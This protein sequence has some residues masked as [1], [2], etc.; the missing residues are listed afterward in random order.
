MAD[1]VRI[2]RK[3]VEVYPPGSTRPPPG[4]GLNVPAHV[5]YFEFGLSTDPSKQDLQRRKL[6]KLAKE[7]HA[8][9]LDVSPEKQTVKIKVE[10]F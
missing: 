8:E 10:H 6:E 9:L 7:K 3:Q 1:L 5:T 4:A 2:E